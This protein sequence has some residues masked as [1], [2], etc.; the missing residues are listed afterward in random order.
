VP[1]GLG[2]VCAASS[3]PVRGI[4]DAARLVPI[5]IGDHVTALGGFEVVDGTR[6]FSAHTLVDHTSPLTSREN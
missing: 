5:R 1:G 3:R 2:D 4:A 6:I